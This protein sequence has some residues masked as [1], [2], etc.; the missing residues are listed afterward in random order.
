MQV[1]IKPSKL[2]GKIM[3]PPSKSMAHRLLICA[4]LSNGESTVSG[5]SFS[6]TA[7]IELDINTQSLG[8]RL[9]DTNFINALRKYDNIIYSPI[10]YKG[11][12]AKVHR[13]YYPRN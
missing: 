3:A 13:F 10:T 12:N 1:N 4:G 2:K 5:I 9:R 6:K 11:N 8:Y 7:G